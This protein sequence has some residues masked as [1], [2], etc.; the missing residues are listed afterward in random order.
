MRDNL[1]GFNALDPREPVKLSLEARDFGIYAGFLLTWAYVA[2]LGRGRA[3]GAPRAS[4]LFA[5]VCFIFIMGFDGINA[6]LY[7]TS[8]Y[9]L[10]LELP[11]R[12]NLGRR[13][14]LR[15]KPFIRIEEALCDLCATL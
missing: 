13:Y 3:S 12:L 5:L 11:Q 8:F 6:F 2:I 15:L 4:I 1:P 7:D 9:Q 10:P 14:T